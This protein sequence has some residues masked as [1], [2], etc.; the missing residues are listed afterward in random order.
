MRLERQIFL[1]ALTV[2][3]EAQGEPRQGKLAVAYNICNRARKDRLSLTDVVFRKFQYSCWNSDSNTRMNLDVLPDPIIEE[4]VDLV[5]S[6][7]DQTEPDPTN[8]A[9]HYLNVELTKS[10]RA[11]SGQGFTLP[12]W[13]ADPSD[14]SKVNEALVTARI[15]EHTFLIA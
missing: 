14:P 15:K 2:A 8:G 9:T 6:A 11:R 13:A 7:Y 10:I 4:C 1:T 12:E 5:R 3:M